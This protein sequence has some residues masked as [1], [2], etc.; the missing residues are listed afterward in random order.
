MCNVKSLWHDRM[1]PNC[2]SV[3]EDDPLRIIRAFT[4]SDNQTCTLKIHRADLRR[5]VVYF[6]SAHDF[7]LGLR[8]ALQ[9]HAYLDDIGILHCDVSE[10]N[11]FLGHQPKDTRGCIMDFD[12]AVPYLPP[13]SPQTTDASDEVINILTLRGAPKISRT[14]SFLTC[15]S[16]GSGTEVTLTS[17]TP[18]HSSMSSSFSSFPMTDHFRRTTSCKHNTAVSR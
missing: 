12:M 5:P 1:S 10:N 7:V 8:D 6:W 9:G 16:M 13:S 14:G 18:N 17:T 2:V 11:I 4:E 3:T 15:P